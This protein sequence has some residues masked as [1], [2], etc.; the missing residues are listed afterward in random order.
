[1]S[2]RHDSRIRF[3]GGLL[4]TAAMALAA[5]APAAAQGLLETLFGNVRRPGPPANIH[6]FADPFTSLL[7]HAHKGQIRAG[8]G[9]AVTY[10]VRTCDGR[11]FPVQ[12]QGR[13]GA[14]EMCRSFCPASKTRVYSGSK[15]DYAIAGDGSRYADLGNAFAYRERIVDRCTCNGKDAFGLVSLDAK[16]DQTL[17]AGDI[18]ATRNGLVAF[19]GHNNGGHANFT[20]IADYRGF[21]QSYR[22]KLSAIKLMPP[23]PGPAG[24]A[25]A[26]P[27]REDPRRAQLSK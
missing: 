8:N 20:P 13:S 12:P 18:V 15:I 10:C 1:M 11:Y 25:A 14:A 21:S 3:A 4:L 6:A 26:E 24:V 7:N 2:G 17:R 22:G 5:P 9:P 27:A 23:N 16:R 19:S